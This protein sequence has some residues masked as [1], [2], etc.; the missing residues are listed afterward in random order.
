MKGI[1]I[2]EGIEELSCACKSITVSVVVDLCASKIV[3]DYAEEYWRKR[4]S[5]CTEECGDHNGPE[6]QN[7]EPLKLSHK[8]VEMILKYMDNSICEKDLFAEI[9]EKHHPLVKEI[10]KHDREEMKYCITGF[11]RSLE[12]QNG[13]KA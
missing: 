2:S 12:S 8:E 11:K 13:D 4:F 3:S 6:S 10:I 1:S 5:D 7:L 9:S